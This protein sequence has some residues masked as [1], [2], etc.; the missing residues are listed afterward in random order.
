MIGSQGWRGVAGSRVR[1]HVV[2]LRDHRD[3]A[4]G[5]A[6]SLDAL[7]DVIRAGSVT[8]ELLTAPEPVVPLRPARR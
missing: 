3:D 8:P 1:R 7:G 2:H 6:T 5:A 4:R